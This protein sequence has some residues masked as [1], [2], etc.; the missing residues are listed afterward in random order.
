M[1]FDFVS[2]GNDFN[3]NVKASTSAP[4]L[5]AD[6]IH[7]ALTLT[8]L[9]SFSGNDEVFGRSRSPAPLP[10]WKRVPFRDKTL[11]ESAA[12]EARPGSTALGSTCR[13]G[14]L[15]RLDDSI[16]ISMR[17]SMRSLGRAGGEE[18]D[19]ALEREPGPPAW[20]TSR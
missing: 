14:R 17:T 1:K 13:S 11:R 2:R 10:I 18:V 12:A 5:L 7:Q 4:L 15:I 3:L 9:L 20:R 16:S 6:L 19:L 8:V